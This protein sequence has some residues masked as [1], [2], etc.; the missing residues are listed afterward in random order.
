MLKKGTIMDNHYTPKD[1]PLC[2]LVVGSR[3][4][5]EKDKMEQELMRIIGDRKDILIVSGEA[6]GADQLAKDFAIRHD[7]DYKGFPAE[8]DKYKGLA[9]NIR[10]AQMHRFIEEYPDRRCIAFW[11]GKSRGTKNNFELAKQ[12]KTTLIIIGI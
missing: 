7:F 9:G 6:T 10:N 11:D 3:T 12:H 1:K 8:W 4:F 5:N 2:L